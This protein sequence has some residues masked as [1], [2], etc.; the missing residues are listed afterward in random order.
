MYRCITAFRSLYSISP[1]AMTRSFA[2]VVNS[3]QDGTKRELK[4]AT[5]AVFLVID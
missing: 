2:K 5:Q 1:K 3:S 4:G